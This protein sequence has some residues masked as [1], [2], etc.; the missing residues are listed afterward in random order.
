MTKLT[1]RPASAPGDVL[2]ARASRRTILK[3]AAALGAVG[4]V[5]AGCCRATRSRRSGELN[6]FTW[7]DY[8]PQPLID[9]FQADTGI[10]LNV[11]T[12]LVERR[13]PQ[14]AEGGRRRRLG[15]GLAI[16]RLGLVRISTTAIWR[17]IDESKIPNLEQRLP[18][19]PGAVEAARRHAA[20]ASGTRCPMTGARRRWPT[21]PRRC[22]S[23][24]ARRRS[25]ICG[26][27]NTR[28]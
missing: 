1:H 4:A 16:D 17:P 22:S 23:S 2:A 28:A 11:T 21:T 6:W 8:A 12:L 3:S 19:L 10:K 5:G 18:E 9:R 24:T 7:E 14:Q 27:P 26:S 13:L 25:A 20:T 15:S